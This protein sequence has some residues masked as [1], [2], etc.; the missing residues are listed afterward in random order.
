VIELAY[1][2]RHLQLQL[3]EKNLA[4]I[5]QPQHIESAGGG[6]E[7]EMPAASISSSKGGKINS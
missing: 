1:G 2:H 3:D 7:M 4:A 6:L 5:L